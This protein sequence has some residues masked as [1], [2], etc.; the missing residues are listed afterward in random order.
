M[1]V[2]VTGAN[3]F[4][5]SH[6]TK[7]LLKKGYEVRA[8]VRKTSD[9]RSLEGLDIELAYGDILEPETIA[10]AL[11]DCTMVFHVA[12]V[13]SYWSHDSTDLISNAK[14]GMQNIME[15]VSGSKVKRVVLTSSSV[16][17]GASKQKRIISVEHPGDFEDAPAYVISKAEQEKLALQLAEMYHIDLLVVN[18]TLTVGAPDYGLTESNHMIVSYLKDPFKTTWIGGCNIVSVNDVVEG[19]ILAAEKGK[20]GERY[21]LGGENLEW[22]EVHSIISELSGLPGPYL[23]AYHTS[24]FLASAFHEMVSTFTG[25]KPSSSREQAKMVGKYYWYNHDKISKLGYSPKSAKAA[26]TA[27]ISWLAGSEHI[28]ASVRATMELSSQIHNYRNGI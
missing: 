23:T 7:A 1:K 17:L 20:R 12:G 16:T 27:V 15:A 8:F 9:L 14:H 11:K 26:L 24:A 10:E 25:E 19:H 22:Q 13:F 4:I 5:G 21:I 3:G 28:P 6:L 18:P 2:L